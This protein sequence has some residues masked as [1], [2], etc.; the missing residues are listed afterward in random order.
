M[1]KFGKKNAEVTEQFLEEVTD[2]QL[3]QVSGG[4]LLSTVNLNSMVDSLSNVANP[5]T[6][7]ITTVS[8]NSLQVR[9]VVG[10][11]GTDSTLI[12]NTLLP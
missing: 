4:S 7:T 1:F 6:Q 5:V 9:P 11:K 2:E 3:D 10:V 12:P 8:G